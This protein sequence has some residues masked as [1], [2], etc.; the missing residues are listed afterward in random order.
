M[1]FEFLD[2]SGL[3]FDR[4]R[5]IIEKDRLY[6]INDSMPDISGLRILRK[7]LFMGELKKNRFEPSQSLAMYIGKGS[8]RILLIFLL[9]ILELSSI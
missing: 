9:M 8:I 1:Y 5:L 7:G 4:S 2:K 6:Y 3:S